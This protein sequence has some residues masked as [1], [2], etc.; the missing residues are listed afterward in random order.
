M[1]TPF[2]YKV[3][4]Q[5]ESYVKV[6]LSGS[7]GAREIEFMYQDVCE[8]AEANQFDKLLV[9]AQN[10]T[11]DFHMTEFVPLMKKVSS[12]LVGF[13]VARVC[14]VFEF[15]QDLIENVSKKSDV[16]LK[17]FTDETAAVT[18]LLA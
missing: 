16:D 12:L 9:D 17:N 8:V 11:L 7:A 13:K 3:C 18:W 14:K 15:R 2:E 1:S 10:L 5:A 6:Y 4:Q